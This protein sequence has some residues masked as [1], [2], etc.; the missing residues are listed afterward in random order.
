MGLIADPC[1]VPI[2]GLKKPPWK[3]YPALRALCN[4]RINLGSA[5]L[6]ETASISK[7]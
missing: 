6:L 7:E 5:I 2:V 4:N 1:G 3:T